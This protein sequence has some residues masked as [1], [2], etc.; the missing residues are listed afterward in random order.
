MLAKDTFLV[1][2]PKDTKRDETKT[3]I[4]V[5]NFTT[6]GIHAILFIPGCIRAYVY[7]MHTIDAILITPLVCVDILICAYHFACLHHWGGIREDFGAIHKSASLGLICFGLD[8]HGR[9]HEEEE[10]HVWA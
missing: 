2:L 9:S 6:F 7:C 8:G 1:I 4:R 10:F 5:G 3:H